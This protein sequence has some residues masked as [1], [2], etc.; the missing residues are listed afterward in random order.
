MSELYDFYL[1]VCILNRLH[2]RWTD[3]LD[4]QAAHQLL[5][6]IAPLTTL[7]MQTQ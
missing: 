5:Q 6:L 3:V 2:Y 7:Q 1:L 4:K